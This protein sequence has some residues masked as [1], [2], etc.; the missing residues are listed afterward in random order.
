MSLPPSMVW[1]SI[2]MSL[3]DLPLCGTPKKSP[4][5]WPLAS[6]RTMTRLSDTSTS[7]ISHLRSGMAFWRAA[8][9]AMTWSRVAQTSLAPQ[10]SHSGPVAR[11]TRPATSFPDAR[12]VARAA[13]RLGRHQ[14][15]VSRPLARLRDQLGDPLLIKGGKLMQ[16]TAFAL[17]FMEQVRPILRNVQRVL[18]PRHEFDPATSRRLF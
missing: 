5:G 4:A 7:L 16:P 10:E 2:D 8:M 3:N 14:S 1:T 6:P 18:L 13:E 12:S 11:L 17:E 15:A 9:P